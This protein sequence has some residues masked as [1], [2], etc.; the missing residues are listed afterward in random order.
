[1]PLVQL[2][3]GFQSL[4]LLPTNHLGLSGADSQGGW[5]CVHSRTLW[6]SP[7]NSPV[8]L[9]VPPAATSTPHVFSVRGFE[10]LFP[11]TGTLGCMVY[12]APQLLLLAYL[13]SN[14]GPPSPQAITLPAPVLQ[15]LPYHE[16]SQPSCLSPPL[17]LVWMNVSSLT[18]WWLDFH[19]VLFSVSSGCFLFLNCCCLS[20]GCVRRH[21]SWTEVATLNSYNNAFALYVFSSA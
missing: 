14:V 8:R 4:P 19:T 21:P 17:L 2:S 18:L 20:F 10:D 9:G 1:M 3:A 11:R 15:P 5:V 12:L 7:T 16:S 13:H 6:F